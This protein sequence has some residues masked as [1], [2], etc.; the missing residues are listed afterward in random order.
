MFL[1]LGR[2]PLR[3]LPALV[4]ALPLPPRY[5]FEVIG[6]G[7]PPYPLSLWRFIKKQRIRK[8]GQV[9]WAASEPPPRKGKGSSSCYSGLAVGDLVLLNLDPKS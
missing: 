3:S 5:R 9:G 8:A 7:M 6:L 4:G 2:Y 1:H